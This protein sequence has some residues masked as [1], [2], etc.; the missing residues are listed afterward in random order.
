MSVA[1]APT[2]YPGGPAGPDLAANRLAWALL[3]FI[4]QDKAAEKNPQ[5]RQRGLR[6]PVMPND[7]RP[8][9]WKV[10]TTA[11]RRPSNAGSRV[12]GSLFAEVKRAVS[13]EDVAERLTDLRY[14]GR[15]GKGLCPFH[16]DRQP[17]F[18]VW[19]ETGTWRCF[20]AC[21]TG[22]DVI[23]LVRHALDVGLRP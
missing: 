3:H 5:L 21:A 9:I 18:V 22:G 14:S 16:D 15:T 2:K 6:F 17:S 4:K 13:I 8:W 23:D 12:G 7:P 10:G 11:T 1:N 20:G 19:P